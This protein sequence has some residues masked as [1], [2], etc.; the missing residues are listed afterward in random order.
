[1]TPHTLPIDM[2]RLK[3]VSAVLMVAALTI[4]SGVLH[5]WL[6]NRW[7]PSVETLHVANKLKEMPFEFGDWRL[8][9]SAELDKSSQEQ[10]QPAGYFDRRYN[11]R[12]TGDVVDVMLLLGRPGP[13]AVHTPEVCFASRN[14]ERCGERQEVAIRGPAG[15]DDEFWSL[16]FKLMNLHGEVVRVYYAWSAGDRWLALKDAHYWSAGLPYFYK[17]QLVGLLPPGTTNLRSDDPC[18]RFLQD[19]IPVARKYLIAPSAK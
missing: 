1:M 16:D 3:F 5:G 4:L 14:C 19:F 7:G 15:A 9:S 12:Q 10:L 13:I 18:Q 17:I 8:Q 6:S 2:K 11:N